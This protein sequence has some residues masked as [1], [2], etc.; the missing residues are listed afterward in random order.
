MNKKTG[1]NFY[2]HI[3][4]LSNFEDVDNLFCRMMRLKFVEWIFVVLNGVEKKRLTYEAMPFILFK[5]VR[6]QRDNAGGV[7]K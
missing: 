4:H 7:F 3:I 5:T 1:K 2:E 6:L